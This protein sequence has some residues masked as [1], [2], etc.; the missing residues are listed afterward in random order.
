MEQDQAV[1]LL[2]ERSEWL[3]ALPGVKLQGE[4]WHPVKLDE[5]RKN[6]VFDDLGKEKSDFR[7]NFAARNGG[8]Q[9]RMIRWLSG[10]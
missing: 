2:R 7:E 9:I 1:K 8:S 3:E 6:D 5:V 10:G 4:Q